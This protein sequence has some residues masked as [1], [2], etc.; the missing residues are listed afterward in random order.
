MD[1]LH[2]WLKEQLAER[3]PNSSG[4]SFGN[5]CLQNNMTPRR[6]TLSI[7]RTTGFINHPIY[8]PYSLLESGG[9]LGRF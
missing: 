5:V 1:R 4:R 6:E 2:H 9:L 8:R 3:R 7:P